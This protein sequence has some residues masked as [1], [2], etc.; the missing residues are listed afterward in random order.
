MAS[1]AVNGRERRG[2]TLKGELMR[3]PDAHNPSPRLYDSTKVATAESAASVNKI[4]T[5]VVRNGVMRGLSSLLLRYNRQ[6]ARPDL[7][8]CDLGHSQSTQGWRGILARLPPPILDM[9]PTTGAWHNRAGA[10]RPRSEAADGQGH[11][12]RLGN[13]DAVGAAMPWPFGSGK[14]PFVG[15]GNP[16]RFAR[17][18][19]A[20]EGVLRWNVERRERSELHAGRGWNPPAPTWVIA[21]LRLDPLWPGPRAR[22]G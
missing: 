7:S 2:G 4:T 15:A 1:C 3:S 13:P 11:V 8:G 9:D 6:V 18:C 10:R 12:E 16:R 19:C 22:Q 17:T 14:G 21:S 20:P 5:A